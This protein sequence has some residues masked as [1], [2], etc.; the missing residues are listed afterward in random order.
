MNQTHRHERTSVLAKAAFVFCIS[1]FIAAIFIT[2]IA[3]GAGSSPASASS[4]SSAAPAASVQGHPLGELLN[5]D[6]TVNLSTHFSGSVEMAGW[7]MAGG[8]N[9]AP[10]F[11]PAAAGDEN[12][13][14]GFNPPGT[15][16]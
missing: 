14:A 11:V 3:L 7:Q 15:N 6:G 9:G 2:S 10:K 16:G 5:A 12:W 8:L 1:A 13:D 4:A